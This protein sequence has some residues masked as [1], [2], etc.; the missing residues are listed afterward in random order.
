MKKYLFLSFFLSLAI[1]AVAVETDLDDVVAINFDDL[2]INIT[3]DDHYSNLGV[4]FINALTDGRMQDSPGV[5]PD[6]TLYHTVADYMPQPY[7]PIIMIFEPPVS[8]VS[9]TGIDVGINGFLFTA[10]DA[11]IGGNVLGVKEAAGS[12]GGDGEFFTL[13][14]GKS[15]IQRVEF[16]QAKAIRTDGIGFDNLKFIPEPKVES[17]LSFMPAIYSL[18]L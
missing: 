6:I 10:Y 15:G 14:I 7:N 13:A 4:T 12:G 11:Q 2:D 17:K 1:N 16:S 9:L 18:L 3:V 8:F 5:S